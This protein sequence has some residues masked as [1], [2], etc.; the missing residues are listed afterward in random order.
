M[1]ACRLRLLK[2]TPAAPMET[3]ARFQAGLL[4]S[5]DFHCIIEIFARFHAGFLSSDDFHCIS[6]IFID[7]YGFSCISINFHEFRSMAVTS[8]RV[9]KVRP[10]APRETFARFQAGLRTFIVFLGFS[11]ISSIFIDLHSFS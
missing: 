7:F 2:V 5:Q 1:R 8:V 3:F 11:W 4:S 6:F 10:A 9:G